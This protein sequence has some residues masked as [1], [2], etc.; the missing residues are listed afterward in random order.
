[1]RMMRVRAKATL[2]KRKKA[3]LK[4]R[5]GGRKR[6]E[7]RRRVVKVRRRVK[8]R[9]RTNCNKLMDVRRGRSPPPQPSAPPIR[10]V[11]HAADLETHI[12]Q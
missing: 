12:E 10:T 9:V 1:M 7:V 8:V 11:T 3:E 5:R 6:A 2:R 4:K